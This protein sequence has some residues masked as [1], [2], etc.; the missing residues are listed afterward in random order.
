L[1]NTG[2]DGCDNNSDD[3]NNDINERTMKEHQIHESERERRQSTSSEVFMNLTSWS[4]VICHE[5]ASFF[6]NVTCRSS[7]QLPVRKSDEWRFFFF[8]SR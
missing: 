1:N 7:Q 8:R 3:D 6:K 5:V 4:G 2:V